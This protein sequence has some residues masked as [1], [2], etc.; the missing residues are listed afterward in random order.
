MCIQD[1]GRPECNPYLGRHG[2]KPRQYMTRFICRTINGAEIV[3]EIR[4]RNRH[5]Y[6]SND[7]AV[8][9]DHK[10][11]KWL[12]KWQSLAVEQLESGERYLI[13]GQINVPDSKKDSDDGV[14]YVQIV[15]KRL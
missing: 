14:R 1:K 4:D 15:G 6:F 13:Y 2:C 10:R 11:Q 9:T 5:I 8:V 12:I 7:T 3:G